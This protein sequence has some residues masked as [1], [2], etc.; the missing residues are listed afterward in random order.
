L[1]STNNIEKTPLY[2][3]ILQH[4]GDIIFLLTLEGNI[5]FANEQAINSYG[6][7]KEELLSL[8]IFNL[9]SPANQ[10]IAHEQ[11]EKAKTEGILFTSTHYRKD[12][13]SFPVEVKSIII[14]DNGKKFVISIIRDIS[15]RLKNQEEI[16][17]LAYIV[18][19]SQDAIFCKT[20]D[21][22]ITSW[23]KGAENIFGYSKDEVLG[24]STK[25]LLPEENCYKIE[26]SM[27]KLIKYV[28]IEHYE[29]TILKKD[30]NLT[31][32]SIALSPI[33]D[34]SGTLIG[35]SIIAR[36]IS[37]QNEALKTIKTI[38][39]ALESSSSAVL[40][41]DVNGTLEYVN[42]K[43]EA[44]TGY[45]KQEVLG[46]NVKIL[47][48]GKHDKKYFASMWKLIKNGY[49]WNGE[50]CNKKKDGSLFWCSASISPVKDDTGKITNFLSVTEDITDKKILTEE[51]IMKNNELENTLALL[52]E[53]QM[54]LV[55]E[56]K[57]ASV[58]QL[59]AGIAHEINNPL[60]FVSSNFNTLKKYVYKLK[61]YIF[62][63]KELKHILETSNL[64]SLSS[65]IE[66]INK[67]E[68]KNKLNYIMADLEDLYKDTED[69][70]NRIKK[71]VATLKNFAH[72]STND[73]FEDYSLNEG[74][75]DT[76]IIAKNELKY[77]TAVNTNL[78]D[79]LPLIKANPSEINQ[80]LLNI[81]INSSHAIKE[82]NLEY[83][84]FFGEITI[85]TWNDIGH[86]YCC[87]KDNGI[88]IKQ[89]NLTKVF[90]PFFTT[91]PVGK[92]T[93]L[94]LSISY[95]IIVNKH[96]GD[97]KIDSIFKKGTTITIILPINEEKS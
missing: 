82:K 55:Q 54:H 31:T 68:E 58:G 26:A 24:K 70:L 71:I 61:E 56:D 45:K 86:V 10:F 88:G 62:E 36:D 14:D 22:I 5:V 90:N 74:I 93:G 96:K 52:K 32:V 30:G 38:S 80:V 25:I 49:E 79:T 51:L 28:T 47:N 69:G 60:G 92:G 83:S 94:G 12:G 50:F 13:S 77:N 18:E 95:D 72:E 59:S 35:A 44:I 37:K 39:N 2:H 34:I 97:I 20:L 73:S 19:N 4:A 42:N 87:I 57:M 16:Q 6:Y 76:L 67:L 1:E 89:E 64:P 21:G 65:E 46:L 81:I 33:L 41:T 15:E 85:S 75:E 29:T 66:K 40:I 11:F 3:S 78:L 84:E 63:I 48:S 8:S 43:F 23:N 7:T 9:R 17:R 91:K 53:A 27:K